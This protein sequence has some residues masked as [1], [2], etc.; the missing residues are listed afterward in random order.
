[1]AVYVWDNDLDTFVD[2]QTREPMIDPKAKAKWSKE[3]ATCAPMVVSDTPEYISPATG[4][5]I[6]GKKARREDLKASGCVPYE[7]ISNRPRGIASER[8]AKKYGLKV[9]EAAAHRQ[10][11]KRID[12]LASVKK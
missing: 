5:L 8:M 1:M 9:N 12:A 2:K 6:D 4:K 11:A 7:P 3:L 10:R